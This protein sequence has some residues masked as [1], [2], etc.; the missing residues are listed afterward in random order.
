MTRQVFPDRATDLVQRYRRAAAERAVEF[1]DSSMVVGLGT[2]R[3]AAFAVNRI[4][5]LLE[6][7]LLRG[8]RCVP[9]SRGTAGLA[10]RLGIPILDPTEQAITID[11]TI[12]GADEVDPE[13]NLIKGG[14]GALLREKILAQV[15]RR[16]IIVVDEGKLS[17]HLGARSPL[18]VEVLPFCWRSQVDYLEGLGARVALRRD[19]D[20]EPFHSDHGNLILD[21][22]F[23]PLLHP[24][25]LAGLLAAG[26][27]IVEHGLFLGLATDLIVAGD[28]R[29]ALEPGLI[30]DRMASRTTAR[31][32]TVRKI[33]I[34]PDPDRLARRVAAFRDDRGRGHPVAP[35]LRGS[36]A[37]G[38]TPRAAYQ[39]IASAEF[40]PRID[41][42]RVH[43][44]WGDERCVPPPDPQSNYRMVKEALLDRVPIP[45]GNIHRIRGEEPPESAAADYE[46]SLRQLIGP[47]GHLDLVL[48]GLG[49]DG[50]TAS[51]FPG[52]AA[53]HEKV[54]WVVAEAIA[55]L[56]AWRITLTPVVINAAREIT[57]VVSGAEK[58]AILE[59]VLRGNSN[60]AV[61]P[62][63]SIVPGAG[64]V[65]WLV[66][67][68]AGE[69]ALSPS[70]APDS[71]PHT[72]G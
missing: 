3:T 62:A 23:G 9:S 72:S 66:D 5:A 58:A 28:W 63:I 1:V 50:H 38:S 34:L 11:L 65:V 69:T 27:G 31:S 35:A 43:A 7:G 10:R 14:G 22:D 54:H 16:E 46:S 24:V 57:F 29:D 64:Q 25:E 6:S 30:G 60:P 19:E 48:L 51:L 15:S 59:Q 52:Q 41:W 55:A 68:A 53:V 44:L 26:G 49:M 56:G 71:H 13:L 20:G 12:D 42:S 2:G 37:G 32:D 61:L 47:T 33:R 21:A 4:G 8:V 39:L 36:V 70:P 67:R 45:A 40:S 17:P 18:P